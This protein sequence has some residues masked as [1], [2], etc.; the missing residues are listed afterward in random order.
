MIKTECESMCSEVRLR[1]GLVDSPAN[2]L[3]VT[4]IKRRMPNTLSL[5]LPNLDRV[6][7]CYKSSRKFGGKISPSAQDHDI[8]KG[9]LLYLIISWSQCV[10]F[11]IKRTLRSCDLSWFER[12]YK[13]L[14][15]DT[16]VE[17]K[18]GYIFWLYLFCSVLALMQGSSISWCDTK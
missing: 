17:I 14:H 11:E 10:S 18:M 12:S 8:S 13:S 9:T 15:Y 7:Y 3:T 16:N 6:K 4:H 1:L 5:Y 2:A